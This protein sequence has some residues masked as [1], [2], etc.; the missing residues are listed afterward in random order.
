MR[1]LQE[2]NGSF[3][4]SIDGSESDM[5]FLYCACAISCILNDWSSVD[6]PRAVD[7]ILSC[8]TYEGAIGLNPGQQIIFDIFQ[9]PLCNLISFLQ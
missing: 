4:A 9:L 6:I 1:H 8:I 3:R 7:Y 2:P 5:R